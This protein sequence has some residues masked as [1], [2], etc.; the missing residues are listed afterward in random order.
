MRHILILTAVL[1]CLA[2][3]PVLA[4]TTQPAEEPA[5][6]PSAYQTGEW[7]Q[8][9][10]MTGDWGGVRKQLEDKGITFA[11]D[12]TQI[13]QDNAHGGAHT[14]NG[15]RY[16]GSGDLTL[17]LD[18]GKMGLWPGGQFVI[19]GEPK[20]GD[21]VN[22][23]VGSLIP[24]NMDAVK[25][26]TG[27]GGIITLSEFFYQQVLF[28][29]KLILIGGKL[30]G[31]RAFDR[32]VFANDERTQFMNVAFRNNVLIAP[33]LPYT[34]M[35]V[36]AVVNPTDWLSISTA[37]ADSSGRAVTTGFETAF[38]GKAET[39][40]IHE[41]AFRIKPFGRPGS[42]KFGFAWSSKEYEYL[43][44]PSPFKE[45]GPLMMSLLG[46]ATANK[47]VHMV[48]PFQKS[49]DNIMV[50]YNFDQYLYTKPDDPS[51][52]FG[53]FGRFGWARNDVNPVEAYYSFGMGGK[54]LIP[55]RAKDTY[56]IGY[57]FCDLSDNLPDI[58]YQENGIEAY[59]SFEITPWMHLSPDLQIIMQPG[60]SSDRDVSLVWG[61][62]LQMNL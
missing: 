3:W 20:W 45:T 6:R 39:T 31:S 15:F 9:Q 29:G 36:G 12:V 33:F 61:L 44:P 32:N 24:V 47:L 30:D 55:T 43:E 14:R 27:D 35:G 18:T 23:K 37:V 17:I 41:W 8:W 22:G 52:G 34:T 60:G 57:Y 62:R 46:P 21:G 13:I 7:W 51:Q 56:G 54:G 48:A 4:Q 16:S 1:G 58:M 59:Y 40:V 26:N 19:N 25:P 53:L 50:Y 42:Q 11:L 28:E 38:H 2:S 49:K 5:A 10:K